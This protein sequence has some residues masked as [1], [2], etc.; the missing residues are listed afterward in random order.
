MN[1]AEQL[2]L[3][4]SDQFCIYLRKSRADAEAEKLGEGETLARHERILKD[5]ATREGL[6][7][8]K[9]YKEIVSG[10]TIADRCEIQ[11]LIKESYEGMWKGILVVEVTRL[12]RGNQGDAQTIMDCLRYGNHNKGM[13]VVTPTKIYDIV[14]STDDE[15]YMEFELFMSRR[16]YKMICNR[17][18]RGKLQAVIE[19]NFMSSIR[20][21]GYD[22]LKLKSGRTLIPNHEEAPVVKKIFEWAVH[23]HLSAGAIARR[24]D[25][26]GIPTYTGVPEWSLDTIKNI[27]QNPTYTGKVR[28]NYR[29]SIKTMVDGKL[30]ESRPRSN[31][32]EQCMLYDGKHEAIIDETL[33]YAASKRFYSDKTK[34]NLKL[35]NPLAGLLF[36]SK[37]KTALIYRHYKDGRIP[38]YFH[39]TCKLC[40]AKSQKAPVV[41]DALITSLK[42]HIKDFE[43]KIDNQSNVNEVNI[44]NQ[45]DVLQKELIK[46]QNKLS[47]LFDGW[48]N[49]LID[50]NEFIKRKNINRKRS[51]SINEQIEHLKNS[52]PTTDE[53]EEKIM[54]LTD[55]LNAL[56][57]PSLDAKEKNDYLKAIIAKIEIHI[58]DKDFVLDVFLKD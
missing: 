44:N 31:R 16:E 49:G 14:H 57:D 24:L 46:Q 53:Y 33:F 35:V 25:A 48:E 27:L 2:G 17:M 8:G 52:I 42:S 26:L 18:K 5:F 56:R 36:C 37:C 47:R 50:D 41:F 30:V 39:K 21:Y 28:W 23:E 32:T 13:L 3:T 54:H 6:P 1:L 20:P 58:T 55:A 19:G 40:K 29:P 11:E 10:E 22:I 4:E 7:I 43:V 51:K 15:E 34:A 38:R 9:I 45:I 12:S